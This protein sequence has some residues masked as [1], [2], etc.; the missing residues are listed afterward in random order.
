M[1]QLG[2]SNG[3]LGMREAVVYLNTKHRTLRDNWRRWG[4]PGKRVGRTMQ[5]RE[6]DLQ[7]WIDRN[8]A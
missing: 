4:L 8:P 6:R 5:F 2:G 1:G 7:A 3:V